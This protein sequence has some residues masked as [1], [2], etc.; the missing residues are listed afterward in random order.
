MHILEQH[1]IGP[2]KSI[3]EQRVASIATVERIAS[4]MTVERF[5]SIGTVERFAFI[6]RVEKVASIVTVERIAVTMWGP[7]SMKWREECPARLTLY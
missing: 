7:S 4:I 1:L 6:G 3:H 2:K 5:A